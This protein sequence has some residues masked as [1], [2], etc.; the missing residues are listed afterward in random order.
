MTYQ[1]TLDYLFTQ[2][3]MF[4][5]SGNSAMKKD[6]T[7]IKV[8]LE[9]LGNPQ[10]K[11]RSIH[12]AGTNGK[13]TTCHLLAAALQAHGYQVG[14]YTSPHYRDF[15]ERIKINASFIPEADVIR[16]VEWL[17][18]AALPIQPSF[19]E[20][21]VAMAFDY[22]AR[23]QP[24]WVIVEVGLGGRLDSTNVITPELSVI[25]NIGFDHMEFLGDTLEKIAFEKGGIIK[26][27][28]PVVIGETQAETT[29]VF[30]DL[31]RAGRSQLIFA[32]QAYEIVDRS[33]GAEGKLAGSQFDIRMPGA[34]KAFSFTTDLGGPHLAK[35][36]LTAYTA[37]I[38]LHTDTF[39][40]N[41]KSIE[42]GWRQV[43]RETFYIGRWQVLRER[44][45]LCIAD[46]AHNAEGLIPVMQRL[47][48]MDLPLHIVLGVVREKDLSKALPLFPQ[49]ATYYFVKADIPRGLAADQLRYAAA[50]EGLKGK[51]YASVAEGYQAAREAA[52]QS[53]GMVFVG[54]SIFTVAEVV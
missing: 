26:P 10:D 19:F 25:T 27:G 5:R 43:S 47:E 50:E 21:T 35:N 15:R 37:L 9:A 17:R 3:P 6:L 48:K 52:R 46:S 1:A 33:R 4:Q 8:L 20:I 45:P 2:L 22:F 36:L 30:R 34:Q 44:N 32:D 29:P 51:T 41:A 23:Q 54:G 24:D 14:M 31:A 49:D 12:V 11:F 38:A 7:N 39:T 28:I 16:F 53:G 40:P 18:Q 42:H 13:G